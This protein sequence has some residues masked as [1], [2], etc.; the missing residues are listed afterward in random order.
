VAAVRKLNPTAIIIANAV[1]IAECEEIYAAGAD[2]VF[3]ARVETARALG[4]AIGMALNGSL[5]DYRARLQAEG[6]DPA[7]RREVLP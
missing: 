5:A 7:Q 1:T 4:E 3:M 6:D 2:Y